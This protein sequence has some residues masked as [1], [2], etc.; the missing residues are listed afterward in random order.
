MV[1]RC[2]RALNDVG[3]SDENTSRPVLFFGE[4]TLPR[5]QRTRIHPIRSLSLLVCSLAVT[6][7]VSAQSTSLT[8]SGFSQYWG[9]SNP[10]YD[11]NDDGVVNG[12]DLSIFLS[13]SGDSSGSGSGSGSGSSTPG[14][15]DT[16]G[17]A[18]P[19]AAGPNAPKFELNGVGVTGP[20]LL[21]GSGF[22]APSV[23]PA[24]IG[25]PTLQGGTANA[26]A[27][28]DFI[29]YRTITE[30]VNVAVV[31]FQIGGID[32]VSFS[33]N[34]GPWVDTTQMRR[35]PQTAVWEYFVT[36]RP[37]D[38]PDGKI[39]V[40]AIVYPKRGVPRVLQG[41]R[42]G[43]ERIGTYSM[44]L[45]N[46]RGGT[47]PAQERWVS[48]TGNDTSDGR[49]MQTAMRTIAKA[50][51]SIHTAQA[52][53][54]GG[55]IVNVMPGVYSWA[56]AAKDASGAAVPEPVTTERWLTVRKAPGQ[57]G[58]VRFT[59]HT[60]EGAV[61]S[62]LLAVEG[63][64]FE[65]AQP[66][67]A[68][69][70]ASSLIWIGN[71]GLLGS[72]GSDT[73][74]WIDSGYSG[75][76][77]T[78]TKISNV[79]QG[80]TRGFFAREVHMEDIGQDAFMQ[81]P[82]VLNCSLQ[83]LVRPATQTWHADVMQFMQGVQSPANENVIVYGFK[84]LDCACQGLFVDTDLTVAGPSWQDFAFVNY[85]CEFA[86][87]TGHTCQWNASVNQLLLWNCSL[88]GGTTMIRS[89][90]P[91]G[92]LIYKDVSIRNSVFTRLTVGPA[93]TSVLD[94]SNNHFVTF[95]SWGTLATSG[96]PKFSNPTLNDYRPLPTSPLFGRVLVPLTPADAN[97]QVVVAPGNAGSFDD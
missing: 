43:A 74:Q 4:P 63:F 52:G 94:A 29:P 36:L 32:K 64:H 59:S 27:R 83:R 15:T 88:I 6:A 26:I 2:G 24:Q 9:T 11:L 87:G 47:L 49:T 39:E 19:A 45:W 23:A 16:A 40:R 92:N 66:S 21:G 46:N 34:G 3:S 14:G 69:S 33:A 38:F 81:V 61:R 58:D 56:G 79:A 44:V 55:G 10:D 90:D 97:L 5:V 96:D 86:Q 18:S 85:F 54:A 1:H 25:D 50:C 57:T 37:Q 62:K 76:I 30:P 68:G 42:E 67:R 82:L 89:T 31:A 51:A 60:S 72:G 22:A 73:R 41:P 78:H 28:W 48:L 12:L 20:Y 77:L 17:A 80:C 95:A 75:G 71:C 93:A 13:G 8:A 53:N 70:T 7:T 91:T 84:A 65:N 35:N